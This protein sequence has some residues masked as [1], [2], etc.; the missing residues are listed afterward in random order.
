MLTTVHIIGI[1]LTVGVL[2]AVSIVSGRKVKDARS[3]TTG[4]KA[5]PWMVCGAILGTLVGGQD[6][7]IDKGASRNGTEHSIQHTVRKTD[8]VVNSAILGRDG[9][10]LGQ[11]T[12]RISIINHK[13]PFVP[14]PD[15]RG[16]GV[17]GR[18]AGNHGIH[19]ESGARRTFP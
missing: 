19:N 1:L 2:L 13:G 10:T 8:A 11:S 17:V 7:C 6:T 9:V 3:F 16:R 5:G 15:L 18:V 12:L 4:G 14:Q